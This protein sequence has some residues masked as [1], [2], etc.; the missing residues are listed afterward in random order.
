ME[1]NQPLR[2][3]VDAADVEHGA[4]LIVGG[5]LTL[6]GMTKNGFKGKLFRVA[7]MAM[8]Y[9]GDIDLPKGSSAYALF[10]DR[11]IPSLEASDLLS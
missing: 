9:R 5:L 11:V 3:Q 1:N 10:R 2:R 7:G 4:A 6:V 8:L